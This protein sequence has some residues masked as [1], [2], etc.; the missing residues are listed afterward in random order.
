MLGRRVF[1]T[2]MKRPQHDK[3]MCGVSVLLLF[4][5]PLPS[6]IPRGPT[7]HGLYVQT[8]DFKHSLSETHFLNGSNNVEADKHF[9]P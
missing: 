5:F 6:Q 8:Y 3:M 7:N 2:K 1:A 4:E 9:R